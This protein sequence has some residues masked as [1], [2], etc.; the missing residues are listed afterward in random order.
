LKWSRELLHPAVFDPALVH[1]VEQPGRLRDGR[2]LNYAFGMAQLP[3]GGHKALTHNGADAGYRSLIASFPAEDVTI[4][5]L[6]NGAADVGKIG[7]GLAEAFLGRAPPP[8]TVTPDPAL[9]AK[10]AGYY[11]DDWGPS[12]QLRVEEGKLVTGR[13]ALRREA[14]F[15]PD[16]RFYFYAPAA[17]LRLLPDGSLEQFI[18]LAGI[19]ETF[20]PAPR[21]A[22]TPAELAAIAGLYHSD[23]LDVTYRVSVAGPGLALSSL[24]SEPIPFSPADADHFENPQ[25]RL[26][27][28]RDTSGKVVALTIGSGRIQH[29]RFNKIG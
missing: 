7:D 9:V 20:R 29:L 24:R 3:I 19:A 13:G 6:S 27:V 17:S 14:S 1:G 18:P 2:Q 11:A 28:V 22:P 12:L 23:E 21:S 5:V 16:G 15:L 8:A 26:G 10:L 4:V 25:A